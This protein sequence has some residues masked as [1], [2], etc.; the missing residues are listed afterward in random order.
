MFTPVLTVLISPRVSKSHLQS[1]R[2]ANANADPNT[3]TLMQ[4][5][6]LNVFISFPF[7][8]SDTACCRLF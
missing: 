1:R 5:A 2:R 3:H 4:G 8:P 6:A 7:Y